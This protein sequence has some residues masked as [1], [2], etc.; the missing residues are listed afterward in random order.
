MTP[1]RD[2]ARSVIRELVASGTE[3]CAGDVIRLLL[4]TSSGEPASAIGGPV[5][6][7]TL[8]RVYNVLQAMSFCGE[9][10]GRNVPSGDRR[11][12]AR[13]YYRGAG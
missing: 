6:A 5:H 10:V 8:G 13:T 4:A 9:I 1:T 12:Y 2:D 3:F 7:R 11:G